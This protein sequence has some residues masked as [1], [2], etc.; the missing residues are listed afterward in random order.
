MLGISEKGWVR[1][2]ANVCMVLKGFPSIYRQPSGP[3]RGRKRQHAGQDPRQTQADRELHSDIEAR[4][5]L[6]DASIPGLSMLSS[7]C[8][9]TGLQRGNR[10]SS[11]GLHWPT[12]TTYPPSG[13]YS[14]FAIR[15]GLLLLEIRLIPARIRYMLR[16]KNPRVRPSLSPSITKPGSNYLTVK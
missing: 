15:L 5:E 16:H 2:K 8:G 7:S 4:P 11:R 14:P 1:L 10:G 3:C 6:G 12:N 13:F 9:M